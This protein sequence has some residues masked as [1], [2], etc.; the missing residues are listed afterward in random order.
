MS[1][2]TDL[3]FKIG[4]GDTYPPLRI[5]ATM[6]DDAGNE[7]VVPNLL[8][9]TVVFSMRRKRDGV[10]TIDADTAT[11][12]SST[13]GILRFQFDGVQN[14]EAAVF[15]ADFFVT[16]SGGEKITVPNGGRKITVIV[17][18]GARSGD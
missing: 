5:K 12:E 2:E 11:V 13:T 6:Q 17:S 18:D 8:G 15:D 16:T 4:K 9:A 10:T 14:N 7:V 1:N 3:V